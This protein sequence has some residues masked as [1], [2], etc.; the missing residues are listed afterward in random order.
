[1]ARVARIV[2]PGR[3]RARRAARREVR[4]AAM[5]RAA[6]RAIRRRG[7][8]VTMTEIAREAGVSKPILYRQFAGKAD[9]HAEVAGRAARTLMARLSADP[10]DRDAHRHRQLAFVIAA[11]LDFV[12]RERSLVGFLRRAP[13]GFGSTSAQP[14]QQFAATLA[15]R[16]SAILR[17]RLAAD[18]RDPG[19]ADAWAVALVG[20]VQ[21]AADWWQTGRAVHRVVLADQL[22]WL[23]WNGLAGLD[24]AEARSRTR[25]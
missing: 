14:A 15:A 13:G 17:E 21:A 5:V 8:A 3:V 11:Y 18:G 24:P 12:E 25:R 23:I 7:P 9:L 2:N 20:Y 19:P 16:M 22:T 4:R 1:M 6:V 10:P